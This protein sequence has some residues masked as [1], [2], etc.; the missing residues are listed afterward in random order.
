[1]I[2][3]NSILKKIIGGVKSVQRNLY[4]PVAFWYNIAI[5]MMNYVWTADFWCQVGTMRRFLRPGHDP[6][7]ERLKREL[8]HFNKVQCYPQTP[9]DMSI[10]A[11]YKGKGKKKTA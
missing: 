5:S 2:C 4:L 10:V 6:V 1:C 3:S 8:F 11:Q 9:R 7:R